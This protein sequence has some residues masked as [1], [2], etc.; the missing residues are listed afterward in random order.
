MPLPL[1]LDCARRL[2]RGTQRFPELPLAVPE[3]LGEHNGEGL[4][5]TVVVFRDRVGGGHTEEHTLIVYRSLRKNSLG[6]CRCCLWAFGKVETC[7][8]TRA[9]TEPL[10]FNLQPPLTSGD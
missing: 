3:T 9:E 5:G 1:H 4:V 8:Q 10:P 7:F 6:V 2:C